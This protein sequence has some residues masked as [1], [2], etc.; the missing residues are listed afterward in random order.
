MTQAFVGQPTW[1]PHFYSAYLTKLS[2]EKY[3]LISKT[4]DELLEDNL[5]TG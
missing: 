3:V 4:T 1:E 2:K 5:F